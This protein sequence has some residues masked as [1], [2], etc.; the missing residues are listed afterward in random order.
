MKIKKI[1]K[2][3]KIYFVKID[4]R[5]SLLMIHDCLF[6]ENAFASLSTFNIF[7]FSHVR[8]ILNHWL[9]K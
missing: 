3:K 5:F 4:S 9:F 7:D 8:K 1:K 6:E 2:I